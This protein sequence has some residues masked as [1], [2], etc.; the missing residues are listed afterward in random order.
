MV[1]IM[2]C[3]VAPVSEGSDPTAQAA[4]SWLSRSAGS[5]H[6]RDVPEVCHR[7]LSIGRMTGCRAIVAGDRRPDRAAVC[8]GGR[9]AGLRLEDVRSAEL[10]P[11][12][13]RLG[14][15]IDRS[16][17]YSTLERSSAGG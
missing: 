15:P 1:I 16:V 12:S 8:A 14:L 2:M 10:G 7:G 17:W 6:A 11:S 5:L 9:G 3:D 4:Q 13:T